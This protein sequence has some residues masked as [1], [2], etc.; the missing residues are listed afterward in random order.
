M[1]WENLLICNPLLLNEFNDNNCVSPGAILVHESCCQRSMLR[2]ILHFFLYFFVILD[3]ELGEPFNID[4]KL[5]IL[6]DFQTVNWPFAGMHKKILH[7]LIIDFQHR[8]R[9]FELLFAFYSGLFNPLKYFFTGHWH[10]TPIRFISYHGVRFAS[11]CLAIREQAAIKT[12]PISYDWYHALV[13]I[14][15]PS[16]LNILF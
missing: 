15:S 7:L 11:S 1:I 16:S 14:S 3:F 8:Y 12:I 6:S 10:N 2:P 9:H 4:S 13:I 5:F